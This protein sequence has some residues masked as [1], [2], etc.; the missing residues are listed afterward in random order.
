[1][2]RRGSGYCHS[3]SD[4]TYFQRDILIRGLAHSE[5]NCLN[6][7]R[8]VTAD[9]N[10]DFVFAWREIDDLVKAIV[11][12]GRLARH[13]SRRISRRDSRL[14]YYCTV[15]VMHDTLQIG[16]VRLG[17]RHRRVNKREYR[18]TNKQYP[19]GYSE[20][21][22]GGKHHRRFSSRNYIWKF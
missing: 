7:S 17:L 5:M 20:P 21:L 6:H 14:G 22:L 15:W 3:R 12:C 19:C 13:I 11:I 4:V 1:D 8:L 9:A 2:V 16:R 10:G 18:E